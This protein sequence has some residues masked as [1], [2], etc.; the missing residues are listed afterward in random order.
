[1]AK[2]KTAAATTQAEDDAARAQAQRTT[3]AEQRRIDSARRLDYL[4]N[5]TLRATVRA[6]I[7][8]VR[9]DDLPAYIQG[10][11]DLGLL[12]PGERPTLAGNILLKIAD[13]PAR[14]ARDAVPATKTKPAREAT[15]AYPGL[16]KRAIWRMVGGREDALD[17]A[18]ASLREQ[19]L[20]DIK[21]GY[22]SAT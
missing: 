12:D 4:R 19:G 6:Q 7:V 11:V 8:G 20:I 15:Q 2:P 13:N 21:R 9:V 1:M 18:L 5:L 17:A 22:Y 14:P 16:D 3:A 10:L